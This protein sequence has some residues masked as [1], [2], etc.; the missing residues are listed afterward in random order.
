VL[1]YCYVELTNKGTITGN[2]QASG[3]TLDGFA[4]CIGRRGVDSMG[5]KRTPHSSRWW[6]VFVVARLGAATAIT[7][8]STMLEPPYL[9]TTLGPDD[10][11]Q[12]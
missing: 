4:G 12:L 10:L 2:V 3:A 9:F 5:I 7:A 1:A 6:H 8:A 11:A